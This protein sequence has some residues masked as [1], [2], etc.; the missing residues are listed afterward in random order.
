MNTNATTTSP[1]LIDALDKASEAMPDNVDDPNF[2]FA[3][4]LVSG[5]T[6]L[7]FQRLETQAALDATLQAAEAMTGVPEKAWRLY[8][9]ALIAVFLAAEGR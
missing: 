7:F 5:L 9:D 1:T 4:Y 8:S 2:D 3:K 6:L